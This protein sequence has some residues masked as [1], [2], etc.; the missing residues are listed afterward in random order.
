MPILDQIQDDV[1]TAMKAGEKDKVQTLR[2]VVADLQRAV[3][4]GGADEIAVLQSAR[5]KRLESAQAFRDGGRDDA[6][7]QEEREAELIQVYLP[8]QISDDELAGIV[9]A[10]IEQTG[11]S[12]P[13][14]MGKVMGAVMP[15][16]KGRADGNR[17]QAAVKERLT[18]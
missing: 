6:A 13:A 17:V 11:A 4:E 5:K 8:A 12:A 10:A 15:Q 14:D 9:A 18:S 2:M 1:K 7:A 3:K 16:V